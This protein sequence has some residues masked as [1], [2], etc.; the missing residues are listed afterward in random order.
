[1][2]VVLVTI[3]TRNGSTVLIH[4]ATFF[5]FFKIYYFF[6]SAFFFASFSALI[7]LVK[8]LYI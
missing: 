1:M 4:T 5:I 2:Q 8:S 7:L 3:Y 6:S